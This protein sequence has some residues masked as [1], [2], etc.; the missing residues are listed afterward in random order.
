MPLSLFMLYKSWCL[1]IILSIN[2]FHRFHSFFMK[3]LRKKISFEI[4]CRNEMNFTVFELIKLVSI[5][6]QIQFVCFLCS[7]SSLTKTLVIGNHVSCII[8]ALC[9]H[10]V[11]LQSVSFWLNYR[12]THKTK[13]ESI[14]TRYKIA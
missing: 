3:H 11:A 9:V 2:K 8:Y 13:V 7:F 14:L 5:L 10:L 6:H 4:S 1:F 12:A